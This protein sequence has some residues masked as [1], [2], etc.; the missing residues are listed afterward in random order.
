MKTSAPFAAASEKP[1]ATRSRAWGPQ[2]DTPSPGEAVIAAT[3]PEPARTELQPQREVE[4]EHVDT[5]EPPLT[6]LPL[7]AAKAEEQPSSNFA[8]DPLTRL[9]Q[10]ADDRG[11]GAEAVE[12]LRAQRRL[13]APAEKKRSR[14]RSSQEQR[15]TE[16]T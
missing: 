13:E 3:V 16:E 5:D 7:P 11:T 10:G 9:W 4:P 15:G 8:N 14:R 2:S 12:A 6:L 1:L